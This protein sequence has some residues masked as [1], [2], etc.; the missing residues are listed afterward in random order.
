[1]AV[2]VASVFTSTTRLLEP[3]ARTTAWQTTQM[4]ASI[5]EHVALNNATAQRSNASEKSYESNVDS[6]TRN[7]TK[8]P[9]PVSAKS[10]QP[11]VT[12]SST[13][14]ANQLAGPGPS[15]RTM[16]AKQQRLSDVIA[17]STQCTALVSA[18]ASELAETLIEVRRY[19]CTPVYKARTM[20]DTPSHTINPSPALRAQGPAVNHQRDGCFCTNPKPSLELKQPRPHLRVAARL[21]VPSASQSQIASSHHHLAYN[22]QHT[23]IHSHAPGAGDDEPRSMGSPTRPTLGPR[24]RTSEDG[25][26]DHRLRHIAAQLAPQ[27]DGGES[28]NVE[29]LMFAECAWRCSTTKRTR[30]FGRSLC[31][32]ENFV[33][34]NGVRCGSVVPAGC[35]GPTVIARDIWDASAEHP[36]INCLRDKVY[37]FWYK[38]PM[39]NISTLSALNLIIIQSTYN[40][41]TKFICSRPYSSVVERATRNGEEFSQLFSKNRTV[42]VVVVGAGGFGRGRIAAA[43]EHQK[44]R[45]EPGS[46]HSIH[47][48]PKFNPARRAIFSGSILFASFWPRL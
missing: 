3:H 35:Y 41:S 8:E 25:A 44:G 7:Q 11:E 32:T 20:Q 16:K 47:V 40:L 15:R 30:K 9:P 31:L 36:A 43:G 14:T 18:C 42:A 38:M 17:P 27:F 12:G 5:L 13:T 1:M 28:S 48:D 33:T 22:K 24:Q 46:M 39:S 2:V 45:A 34:G 6:E 29:C 19:C 23:F 4:M 26:D 37:D 21:T 10:L